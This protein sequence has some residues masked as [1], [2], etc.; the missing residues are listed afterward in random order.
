MPLLQPNEHQHHTIWTP[1]LVE[2]SLPLA[3]VARRVIAMLIDQVGI[4]LVL[5]GLIVT[6]F[7]VLGMNAQSF[8]RSGSEGVP[9]MLMIT[10]ISIFLFCILSYF[11]YFWGFH[12]FNNGQ[13]LGKMAVGIRVVTDR[14][15]HAG[16]WT[17]F[18]RSLFDLLDMLLFYGGVSVMMI[19]MTQQEK[20]IADFAA[21][22]IVILDR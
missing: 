18:V 16:V 19:I 6:T 1:E 14:G 9:M 20:R 3:G 10:V 21:G 12:T 13:T 22:T 4:F 8:A 2:I 7:I 5:I 11:F 17:C 15:G